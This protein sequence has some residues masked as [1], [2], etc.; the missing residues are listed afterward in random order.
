MSD[1]HICNN[2][3]VRADDGLRVIVY[4]GEPS[5]CDNCPNKADSHKREQA[6]LEKSRYSTSGAR[7]VEVTV[8]DL[9]PSNSQ[10]CAMCGKHGQTYLHA[11]DQPDLAACLKCCTNKMPP[12]DWWPTGDIK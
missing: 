8:K 3:Q 5:F 6:A 10:R 1:R 12:S 11:S 7:D 4:C 2:T 9:K